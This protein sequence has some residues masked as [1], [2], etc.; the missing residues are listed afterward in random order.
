MCN[1]GTGSQN[2]TRIDKDE[3]KRLSMKGST[4]TVLLNENNETRMDEDEMDC[5]SIKRSTTTVLLVLSNNNR[6]TRDEMDFNHS[7]DD[8]LQERLVN[9]AITVTRHTVPY[10]LTTTL[11]VSP[12]TMFCD[13]SLLSC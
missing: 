10:S 9:S 4:S 7:P 2:E 5:F 6:M 8:H 11:H 13:L 3:M 12:Q 1:L